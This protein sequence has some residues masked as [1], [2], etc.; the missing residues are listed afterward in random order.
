[1]PALVEEATA[2]QAGEAGGYGGV[3]AFKLCLPSPLVP[4]E[5]LVGG[6]AQ[7]R[8]AWLCLSAIPCICTS[9]ARTAAARWQLFYLCRAFLA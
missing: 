1:M 8:L 9:Q 3:V 4:P 7:N 2:E 5:V 6:P